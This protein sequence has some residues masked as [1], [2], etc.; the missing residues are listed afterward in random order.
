MNDKNTKTFYFITAIIGM[1][2]MIHGIS[3]YQRSIIPFKMITF[4]TLMVTLV[5]FLFVKKPYQRVYH[6]GGL[7]FA[8]IQSFISF[9]FI[10]CYLF[11]SLNFYFQ[12]SEV[13]QLNF[14]IVKKYKIGT[15]YWQAAIDI[16][17]K[18]KIKQ[19]V[20]YS[21][22]KKQIDTSNYVQLTITQGLFGYDVLKKIELRK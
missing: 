10:A 20:F 5:T 12:N 18:D 4:L 16:N 22:Q 15:R 8:F 9:G 19:L 3:L 13:E 14:E 21:S 6:S 17:Y 11:I 1:T 2:V 7:F